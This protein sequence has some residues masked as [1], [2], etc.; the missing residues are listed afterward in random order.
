MRLPKGEWLNG[1][2]PAKGAVMHKLDGGLMLRPHPNGNVTVE[3]SALARHLLLE[4]RR[5]H[6]DIAFRFDTAIQVLNTVS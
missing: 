5:L 4:A 3:R 6:P 2:A 1:L